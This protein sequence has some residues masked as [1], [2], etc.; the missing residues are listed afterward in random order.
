M[1]F[2]R[3]SKTWTTCRLYSEF[4]RTRVEGMTKRMNCASVGIVVV[5]VCWLWGCDKPTRG[6]QRAPQ[7]SDA[8]PAQDVACNRSISAL[9]CYR[10]I[11]IEVT[12]NATFQEEQTTRS[13][14][15]YGM[16]SRA[17]AYRWDKLRRAFTRTAENNAPAPPTSASTAVGFSGQ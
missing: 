9:V 15:A 1:W 16:R 10:Q 2:V 13:L 7:T 12:D 3:S 8:T 6:P 4:V 14:I 17:R 5:L 11:R